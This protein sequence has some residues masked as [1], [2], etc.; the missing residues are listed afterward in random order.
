MALKTIPTAASLLDLQSQLPKPIRDELWPQK[1]GFTPTKPPPG[2]TEQQ[3]DDEQDD[4]ATSP[5]G[6]SIALPT[7]RPHPQPI[8]VPKQHDQ[9]EQSYE[10]HLALPYGLLRFCYF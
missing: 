1:R 9:Q 3:A 7:L 2:N 8:R 10:A 4:S 5:T 6:I